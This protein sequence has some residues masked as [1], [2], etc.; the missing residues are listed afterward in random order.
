VGESVGNDQ[1]FMEVCTRY[2]SIPNPFQLGAS[3]ITE[4]VQRVIGCSEKNSEGR[5]RKQTC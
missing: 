3:I 4:R 1:T 5:L 2:K